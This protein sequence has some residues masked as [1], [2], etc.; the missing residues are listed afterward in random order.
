[1]IERLAVDA[2]K[3]EY[4]WKLYKKVNLLFTHKVFE[5]GIIKLTKKELVDILRFADI[6]SNSAQDNFRNISYKIISMLFE[7]YNTDEIF[8]TYS[9]AVLKKLNNFPAL[10][11]TNVVDLPIERELEFLADKE[12]LQSPIDKEIYFLPNQYKIYKSLKEGQSLTFSGPTSMGKSFVIKQF[13]LEMI[14]GEK[15]KKNYCIIVPSRAL[16]K[17]YVMELNSEI[18]KFKIDNY[19]VVTNANILEFVDT[20]HNNFIFVLT[21]ERLN[22]LLFSAY[23]IRLDY[24]IIDEA[25]KLY[26]ES[27]RGLTLYSAVDTCFKKYKNIKVLFVSPLICNPEIFKETFDNSTRFKIN[28]FKSNESPVGQNLFYINLGEKTIEQISD[29]DKE[30]NIKVDGYESERNEFY[31][32]I[33]K[34][35]NNIVYLSSPDRAITYSREF[36]AHLKKHKISL[37]DDEEKKKI[38][39]LCILIEKNIHKEFFLIDVLREGVCYHYGRLPSIIRENV[40]QLFKEGIIKYMFCTSTLLEGVNLPA[41]NIFIMA[42]FISNYSMNPLEFWNLAGRAGRLGY[43]YYGNVFCLNDN[44]HYNAW[45][46]KD[47]L[48]AKDSIEI[49]DK[50]KDNIYTK[51]KELTD[52]IASKEPI[53]EVAKSSI[54]LSLFETV[55]I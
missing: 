26:E 51:Q 4:F 53:N 15:K 30:Y 7:T 17:Q 36:V 34:K 20:L 9:T 35:N 47:V 38:N 24:L 43:E 50:L 18:K 11:K 28:S 21:Q 49:K 12:M 22:V 52:I 25:Y 39:D 33:G 40:E 16:I 6:F 46:K 41:K 55:S 29:I 13:I 37:L 42:N 32:K 3:S 10:D 44:N 23:N 31:Y 1:M 48:Y 14:L 5:L 2:Y 54:I 8:N 19:K 45:R 27:V